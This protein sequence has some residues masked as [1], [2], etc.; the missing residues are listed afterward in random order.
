[1]FQLVE[2]AAIRDEHV[3]VLRA[4]ALLVHRTHFGIDRAGG[5]AYE[6]RFLNIFVFGADG[7]VIRI[8]WFDPDRDAEALARFDELVGDRTA[9]RTAQRRIRPNAALALIARLDATIAD[10]DVDALP[11]LYAEETEVVDRRAGG[12]GGGTWHRQGVL[13]TWRALLR[14]QDP[15]CRHEPLATL[16]AALALSRLSL[17]ASGFAGAN[18]DVGP[19]EREEIFLHEVDAQGRLRRNEIFDTDRLG[20][21]VACLYERYAELLPDGPAR[22]SAAATARSVAILVGPFDVE[23]Y[24]AVH[25]P[26]IEVVDHRTLGTWFAHGAEPLMRN[27]GS[28]LDLT[29]DLVNRTDDVLAVRA[30]SL[31]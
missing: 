28:L 17:R 18:F 7:L 24:R 4:D 14:A 6:R 15:K 13:D 30:D 10:R 5:G 31:L 21:A 27:F 16:G 29:A 19:Y 23:R 22:A 20:D 11:A 3:L 8:E 25:A 12:V 2:T 1:M 26:G 9:G